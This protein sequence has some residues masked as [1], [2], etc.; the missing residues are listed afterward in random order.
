MGQ[1][2]RALDTFPSSY[3][4][5]PLAVLED[6]A[7]PPAGCNPLLKEGEAL[8]LEEV[9][10][11]GVSIHHPDGAHG[12]VLGRGGHVGQIQLQDP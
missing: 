10:P 9:G 8:V 12:C 7:R 6:L 1:Q 2:C 3:R 5:A 11:L 4:Q